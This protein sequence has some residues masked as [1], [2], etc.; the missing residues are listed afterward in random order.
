MA[1]KFTRLNANELDAK[2]RYDVLRTRPE[3]FP[4]Q[5]CMDLLGAVNQ[6]DRFHNL[7]T[8]PLRAALCTRLRSV[9]EYNL[10]FYS[11]LAF[12]TRADPF[13]SDGVEFRCGGNVYSIS[14]A[15]FGS[16][17]GLYAEEDAGDEENTGGLRE[18]PENQCQATWAQIGEG[19][20]NPSNTKSTKLRDPLYRY[21]HRVL[22]Y[23]LS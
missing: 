8:G 21:I 7:V 3:E 22:T 15:Q 19:N 13:D 6:L 11:T 16:I 12:K 5:V 2:A 23:S 14:I 4:R 1:K 20:Y 18:I 10:E 9:H 17:V